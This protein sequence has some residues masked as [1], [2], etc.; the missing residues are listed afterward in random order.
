MRFRN[1]FQVAISVKC[2]CVVS[3]GISCAAP[4][5]HR[6][7]M[8][9]TH[10][11]TFFSEY[12]RRRRT[13]RRWAVCVLAKLPS[14]IQL[15]TKKDF[16]TRRFGPSRIR[17]L[18][19]PTPPRHDPSTTGRSF[20]GWSPG[21]FDPSTTPPPPRS[22][23]PAIRPLNDST[24]CDSTPQRPNPLNDSTPLPVL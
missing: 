17:F 14:I 5:L 13:G 7:C 23:P 22:E 3:A 24:L 10:T 19:H 20:N 15:S 2:R 12:D 6:N 18:D 11:H 21:R 16:N 4:Q 1:C 9:A 8:R